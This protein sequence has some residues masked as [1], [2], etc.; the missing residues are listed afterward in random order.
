MPIFLIIKKAKYTSGKG[1]DLI[2][3]SKNLVNT[4][5]VERVI[6]VKIVEI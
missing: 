1:D 3:Q 6:K 2:F 4:K 5:K